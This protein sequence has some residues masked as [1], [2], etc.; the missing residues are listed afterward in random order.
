MLKIKSYVI[1]LFN[2]FVFVSNHFRWNHTYQ[3]DFSIVNRNSAS[4]KWLH[5]EWQWHAT[6]NT[7]NERIATQ[8][9]GFC[10]VIARAVSFSLS[11][12]TYLICICER[13]HTDK[14]TPAISS[15]LCLF[16][17]SIAGKS[18]QKKYRKEKA[19][20]ERKKGVD[21]D[22]WIRNAIQC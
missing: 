11:V 15:S 12:R 4:S 21:D 5:G 13:V 9:E 22:P 2:E 3:A 8:Y 17:K 14:T 7:K 16:C 18:A 19:K 20:N 6:P 1:S 10:A